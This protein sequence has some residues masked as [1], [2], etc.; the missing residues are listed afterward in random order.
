[1]KEFFESLPINPALDPISIKKYKGYDLAAPASFWNAS[2][3]LRA[4]IAGGCGPGGFGDVFVPDRMYG[5]NM[6]AACAIHDWCF[7]VWNTKAGFK[8]ANELFKNNMIRI[9][10]QHEGYAFITALRSRRIKKYYLAVRFG[11]EPS[12]YDSH[13]QYV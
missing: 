10:S 5:L 13:L 8:Q 6:V 3:E 4:A 9:N 2:D 11:G 7:A 1:M 12:Y